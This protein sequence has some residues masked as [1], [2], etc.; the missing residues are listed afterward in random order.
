MNDLQEYLEYLLLKHIK[1]YSNLSVDKMQ[2][3]DG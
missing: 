2:P 3:I 1:V